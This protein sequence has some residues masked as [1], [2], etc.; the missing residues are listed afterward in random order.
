MA[1]V[2]PQTYGHRNISDDETIRKS[3]LGKPDIQPIAPF[4]PPLTADADAIFNE[5]LMK[6]SRHV[7][8]S[9]YDVE[10]V[11]IKN[12]ER[13]D[14]VDVTDTQAIRRAIHTISNYYNTLGVYRDDFDKNL[15]DML[16]RNAYY[17]LCEKAIMDYMGSAEYSVVDGEGNPVEDALAFLERPNPQDDFGTLSKM[18]LRDTVRYDAGVWVKSF[19]AGGYLTEMKSYLGTEFWKEQDRV[20]MIVNMP[21]SSV[22]NFDRSSSTYATHWQPAYTGWWSH[23]YVERYWQ[24]SR[25]GVYIPFQ[26]EEICYFMM[27]PRSDGIYGTDFLKYL[28]YQLQYLIDSTKAAGKTFENGLVPSLVWM[29]E[30]VKNIQQLEQRIREVR[31]SNQGPNRF[32]SV[33]HTVSGEK[34]ESLAQTLL[35][36]QWLE[37]QKFIAQLIWAMW[38]FAPDEFVGEGA[39]RATAY[40]KRNV[41]KSRLLYPLMT[42]IEMKVNREVLPHI[43]GYK[44]GWKFLYLRDVDLDDDQ[45]LAQTSATRQSIV[46]GYISL[47]YTASQSMKLA[48]LGKELKMMDEQSLDDQIMQFSMAQE[49]LDREQPM[50]GDTGEGRYD[51]EGGGVEGYIDVNPSDY[52]QG[53]E[54]TEQRTGDEGEK[55]YKKAQDL[56]RAEKKKKKWSGKPGDPVPLPPGGQYAS[57]TTAHNDK[58]GDWIRIKDHAGIIRKAE[59]ITDTARVLKAKVYINNPSEAPK[60]RAV[61]RGAR[62][63]YY[64]ITTERKPAHP[65]QSAGVR[66]RHDPNRGKRRGWNVKVGGKDEAEWNEPEPPDV[67]GAERWMLVEGDG[68]SVY[69]IV[70]GGEFK[71]KA[72]SNDDS[73]AFL[74][75][76]RGCLTSNDE[77]VF[78]CVSRMAKEYG[79]KVTTG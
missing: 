71:I 24:R 11:P 46:S 36:M 51:G 37:G 38:G 58:A 73:K 45:K 69:F 28:R 55:E 33:L 78:K 7:V 23:G 64:Y 42:H 31:M 27:Y 14:A 29:H 12:K 47:G 3:A 39:N 77:T 4:T 60:G 18:A 72:L 15:N 70:V 16:A 26:P 21:F 63:G 59:I 54:F 50:E 56:P 10:D 2:N 34:V 20:A 62:G 41:T 48:G 76:V 19:N 40:V 79:L 74:D 43:K 53:G 68:V 13:P 6:G 5:L 65:P 9:F 44:R 32:G 67:S 30:N 52:G 49:G 25:T 66:E 8:P 17:V 35:N 1:L 75:Y 22:V 57:D 61:K